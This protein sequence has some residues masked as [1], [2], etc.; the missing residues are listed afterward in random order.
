M[1]DWNPRY[2]PVGTTGKLSSEMGDLI[3]DLTNYR[4]LVR[5]I[6]YMA[7]TRTDISYVQQIF[8]HMNAPQ[9]AY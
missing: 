9:S 3:E 1:E 7:L 8:L 2:T 6:Q 4:I 5:T